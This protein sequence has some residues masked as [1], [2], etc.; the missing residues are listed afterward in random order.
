[1]ERAGMMELRRPM[2]AF[3]VKGFGCLGNPGQLR[4]RGGRVVPVNIEAGALGI[5]PT[6]CDVWSKHFEEMPYALSVPGETCRGTFVKPVIETERCVSGIVKVQRVG[7][8]GV[9]HAQ[10]HRHQLGVEQNGIEDDCVYRGGSE[11]RR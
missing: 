4:D 2:R 3:K 11:R 1:M 6:D 5:C 8:M 9:W 10:A 7:D